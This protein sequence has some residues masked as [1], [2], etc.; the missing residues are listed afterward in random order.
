MTLEM[1]KPLVSPAGDET[2]ECIRR[3]IIDLVVEG[4]YPETTIEAVVVRAGV[5]R[6]DFERRFADKGDCCLRVY[7][8]QLA[9]LDRLVVGAYLSH[10]A[11]RD[12]LRAAA[13]A[14]ASYASDHPR[15]VVFGEIQM[16]EGSE[17]VQACRDAYLQRMVD[18]VDAG[19]AELD[20]PDSLGRVAAEQ[21]LGATY[22]L[23]LKRLQE[24][25]GTRAIRE[26]VP[27]LMYVAV[28]PYVGH[29]VAREELRIPPPPER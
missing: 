20:D 26:I 25:R 19:R 17:M 9:D 18:L 2:W 28:R 27:E 21:A 22:T 1:L 23:L 13:Y 24:E 4:G 12:R 5:K 7:E 16:R 8:A 15:E 29:E 14:A 10:E 6:A 3:A 11:W